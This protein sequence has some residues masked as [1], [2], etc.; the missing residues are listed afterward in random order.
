MERADFL[1][2]QEWNNLEHCYVA[3]VQSASRVMNDSDDVLG[4]AG[5]VDRRIFNED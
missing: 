3:K 4:G 2:T 5:C 1:R